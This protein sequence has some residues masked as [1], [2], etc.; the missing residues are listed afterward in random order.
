MACLS[1]KLQNA[2]GKIAKGYG[3][4]FIRVFGSSLLDFE[5]ARDVDLAVPPVSGGFRRYS[6]LVGEFERAFG[7]PVDLVMLN[8]DLSPTLVLEI[9]GNSKA[10]WEAPKKGRERY[11]DI[12]DP[13][14]AVAQDEVLAMAVFKKHAR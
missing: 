1:P 4:E 14:C 5:K 12:M 7:K 13:L 3:L 11:A 9:A 8:R 6:A 2:A 10:L